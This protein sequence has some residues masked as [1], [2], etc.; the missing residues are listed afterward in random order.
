VAQRQ[1]KLLRYEPWQIKL[2]PWSVTGYTSKK[3]LF[4]YLKV[5]SLYDMY[6]IS[7]TSGRV[8]LHSEFFSKEFS[9]LCCEFGEL[10]EPGGRKGFRTN[11]VNDVLDQYDFMAENSVVYIYFNRSTNC[12]NFVVWCI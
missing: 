5:S 7:S 9:F 10:Q 4:F 8:F 1:R 12:I 6:I 3:Y 11:S 2:N